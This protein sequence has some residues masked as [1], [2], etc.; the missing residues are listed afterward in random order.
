MERRRV[1]RAAVLLR[2]GRGVQ[3]HVLQHREGQQEQ[4]RP[5][6]GLPLAQPRQSLP[7]V[8]HANGAAL[9]VNE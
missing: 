2:P 4:A 3:A 1:L 8:P 7:L 5:R 6:E 9:S